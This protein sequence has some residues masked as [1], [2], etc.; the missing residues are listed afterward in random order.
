MWARR[1]EWRPGRYHPVMQCKLVGGLDASGNLTALHMRLSGQSIL[2]AVR[3]EVVQAQKG[4]DPLSFQGVF[5]SGEHSFSYTLPNLLIDHAMRN[6]HL[7][8]GVWRGGNLTPN[9]AFLA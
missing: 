4:R 5:E 1:G 2:A 6:T 7:P 9:T 8:P 3:P